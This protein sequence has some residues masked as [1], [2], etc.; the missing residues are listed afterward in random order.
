MKPAE[1][2]DHLDTSAGLFECWP[3][4]RYC[5]ADGYGRVA[6]EGER[7]VQY[8]HRTAYRLAIGEIAAGLL[9]C[10]TCDNPPCCNPAHLFQGTNAD[11]QA[12]KLAKGREAHCR[13][14]AAHEV[15]LIHALAHA[16]I[17]EVVPLFPGVSK[18]TIYRVR[19]GD[20]AYADTAA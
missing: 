3:W 10:H 11:N 4:T 9:V 16:P 18:R 1:F 5:N 7:G 14:L 6:I 13:A 17:D 19:A 12:D 15:R 20:G 8:A 2:W